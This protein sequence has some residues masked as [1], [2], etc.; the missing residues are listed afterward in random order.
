[1]PLEVVVGLGGGLIILLV[2]VHVFLLYLN[3]QKIV[4][5]K[6]LQKQWDAISPEKKNVD[7]VITQLRGLEGNRK[8]TEGIL[9]AQRV[10]WSQVLNILSDSIPSGVWL[11]RVTLDKDVL[12]IEGSS[13]SAHHEEMINVHK[14]LAALQK[15]KSFL[16]NVSELEISSI[17]RRKIVSVDVADFMLTARLK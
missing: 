1:M 6:S 12:L 7:S 3:V 9:P 10:L 17:Q 15:Q 8:S 2:L 4:E 16:K 13:I 5:H 11:R 14:F